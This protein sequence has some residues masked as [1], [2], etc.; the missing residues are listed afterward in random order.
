[1]CTNK[2]FVLVLA[3]VLGTGSLAIAQQD[4]DSTVRKNT[5]KL[6]LTSYGLYRNAAMFS[7]ERVAKNNPNQTWSV[8]A[9]YQ[10][11]PALGGTGM[12]SIN[13]KKESK[14]AGFKLG[15]EYRFY[16]AKENKYKAPR[17]VYIGPYTS[18]HRYSNS[19]SLEVNNNGLI[20]YADLKTDIAIFNIGF[21]LGYQFVLNNRWTIDMVLIGPS[22]SNYSLRST[23][24]GNYTFNADDVTN[25]V[26][27]ALMNK[28]PAF[29]QLISESEF[30]TN[31]R[32]SSWGLGYRYQFH[33]GYHFGR[34]RK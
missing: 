12:G 1:M 26:L 24:D 32:A 20:E 10:Q 3:F 6:D 14:A 17:G 4:K 5:I 15:G 23:M 25:E 18:F 21:Q 22:V 11:F 28:F 9:G 7:Y 31:G 13:V 2:L 29:E 16:L 27:K 8:T 34:K 33:L 30:V 19:R